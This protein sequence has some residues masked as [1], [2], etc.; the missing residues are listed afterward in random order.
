MGQITPIAVGEKA[1]ARMLDMSPAKFRELVAA[2]AFPL[3]VPLAEGVDRWRVSD[4][5]AIL[6]GE[7]A[8]PQ[9]EFEM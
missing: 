1:A 5:E 2:G 8:R 9:E 4:L 7:A 6:N 3:P